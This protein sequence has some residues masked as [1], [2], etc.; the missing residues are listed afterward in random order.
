[1]SGKNFW[2]LVY[3]ILIW[4]ISELSSVFLF[5]KIGDVCEILISVGSKFVFIIYFFLEVYGL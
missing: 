5:V 1:M 4:Y 2:L 3:C